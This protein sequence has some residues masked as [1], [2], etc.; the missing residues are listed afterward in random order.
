MNRRW[1]A[2]ICALMLVLAIVVAVIDAM[3]ATSA[4]A[5]LPPTTAA[6]VT[7]PAPTT[8][9]DPYAQLRASLDDYC[10]A[11]GRGHAKITIQNGA[12]IGD[13]SGR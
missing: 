8:T 9:I 13:C 6:K 3:Q 10:A 5:P 4:S 2:I 11:K 12:P 7:V 1:V